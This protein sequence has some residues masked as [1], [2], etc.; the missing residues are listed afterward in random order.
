MLSQLRELMDRLQAGN[1]P[2]ARAQQQR[3][4]QMMKKLNELDNLASKQ[5]Q[6]MDETFGEQ[7]RQESQKPQGGSQDNPG[8]QG[9]QKPGNKGQQGGSPQGGQDGMDAN[10]QGGGEQGEGPQGSRGG[11]AGSSA[12]RAACRTGRRNSA[13]N[14]TS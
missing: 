14:S 1:S 4:Q 7:R 8:G 9:M 13:T 2:E 5:Q 3:A 11:Q 10:Q 12:A 6:L